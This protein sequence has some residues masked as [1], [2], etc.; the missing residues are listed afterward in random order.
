MSDNSLNLLMKWIR[1]IKVE[2]KNLV[3]LPLNETER[4][5][6]K[7]FTKPSNRTYF[8]ITA[9]PVRITYKHLA[10]VEPGLFIRLK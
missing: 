1:F 7:T 8:A 5:L 10:C 6:T 9:K 4:K 3:L 2:G